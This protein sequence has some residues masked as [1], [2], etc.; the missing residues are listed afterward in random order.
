MDELKIAFLS[1]CIW[2]C[3]LLYDRT[4]RKQ[5]FTNIRS[6][7]N[8]NFKE[9]EDQ[10]RNL[11]TNTGGASF[12]WEWG[13][14][15][16]CQNQSMKEWNADAFDIE[17]Q[18]LSISPFVLCELN[19]LDL[20]QHMNCLNTAQQFYTTYQWFLRTVLEENYWN[21]LVHFILIT[22]VS[23]VRRFGHQS[24]QCCQYPSPTLWPSSP[25][26]SIQVEQWVLWP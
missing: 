6:K 21:H 10:N 16:I 14:A 13:W 1:I 12:I 18:I 26:C 5:C 15:G 23:S 3:I 9:S 22:R 8:G 19:A 2:C 25:S 20:L 24:A 4:G 17:Q 7:T 11:L